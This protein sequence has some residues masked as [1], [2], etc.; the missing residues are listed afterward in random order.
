MSDSLR[1]HGLQHARL[2]CPSP[3]P[4]V[5]S[6]S[7][8]LHRWCHP[9]IS[10]SV[11]PFSHLQ[12]FRGS[13]SFPMSQFFCIRWPKYRSFSSVS[14][15]I[16]FRIDWLDLLAVQ[17]TLKSLLHSVQFSRSV[18][19]DS[20]WPHELQH[21]R[22]PCPSPTPGVYP[23]SCPLSWWCHP[24]ISSSVVP[25]S[26]CP[27]FLPASGSFPMSQLFTWGGQSIR[28]SASAS[29]LPM[30]TQDWSPL[31]WTDWISLQSKG[32]STSPTPQF[33][34]I[35]SSVLSFLYSP[36]LTSIHD[37]WKNHSLD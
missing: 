37:H 10:S 30:N 20:L 22:P 14:G 25:F 16:S 28:V 34:S 32:L 21:A 33:K 27:Q 3:T 26:S 11:V 23:N 4:R 19:S 18:V 13:G 6:N 2:A 29:V 36:T 31:G 17:G 12:S 7:C 35:N 5:Y 8:P 1:P 24:A 9:T 15:L